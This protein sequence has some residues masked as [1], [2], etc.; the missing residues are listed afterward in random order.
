MSQADLC[1]L[2]FGRLAVYF[3]KIARSIQKPMP[4]IQGPVFC[5]CLSDNP[6]NYVALLTHV[7]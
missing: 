6:N 2:Y 1:D 4:G 7:L 3:D 5:L